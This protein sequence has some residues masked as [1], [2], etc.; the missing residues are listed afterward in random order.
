MRLASVDDAAEI[1]AIYAPYCASTNVTFEVIPPTL[2]QMRERIARI[3][4]EYPWLVAEIDGRVAGYVYASR[5]RERAAYRWTAEVAAYVATNV[6]RR[7][8]G[9]ALYTTLISILRLQGFF[10]AIAGITVPNLPSIGLHESVGFTKAGVFPAVG[11]KDG[12]WLDVGWWE[13]SLRPEISNPPDP[14]PI[15]L[16]RD[17]PAL[18]SALK[19]GQELANTQLIGTHVR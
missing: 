12:Q 15:R 8:L 7:G 10:K 17:S 3:T 19:E 5:F 11:H 9:R 6:Q 16:L 13:L 4:D 18:A 1:L 2:E 14:Q